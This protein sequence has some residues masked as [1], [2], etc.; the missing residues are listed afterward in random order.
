VCILVAEG[1]LGGH[2]GS[3]LRL[4]ADAGKRIRQ[5]VRRHRAGQH[6]RPG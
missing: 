4:D 6:Q 3:E 1:Q 2:G 5:I